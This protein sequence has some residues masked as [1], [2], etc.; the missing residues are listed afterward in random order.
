M[1]Q[2]YFEWSYLK[3]QMYFD[4]PKALKKPYN[5]W[6]KIAKNPEEM[7]RKVYANFEQHLQLYQ[8]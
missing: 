4:K 6:S 8:S 3:L 2:D 1:P 7:L 5:I